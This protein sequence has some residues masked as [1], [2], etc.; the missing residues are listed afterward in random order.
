MSAYLSIVFYGTPDFAVGILDHILRQGFPVVG[1][2]TAPD[3]PAGR[4]KKL[5]PSAVK[6]YA[7]GKEIPLSQ[8]V[9]LKDPAFL[10]QLH[11][12]NPQ[13]Q[14]VVAFRMLPEEIW[15][16][17]PLG[18]FNLHASLLPQYRGAAPIQW[19]L[20]NGEKETGVTTFFIDKDIDTGK[21]ILQ[22]RVPILPE[23][24]AGSLM[25]KLMKA[26]ALLTVKT[27]ETISKEN[28]KLSGQQVLNAATLAK[29]P[30][31]TKENLFLH[32]E[33]TPEVINNRI[34]AFSPY[35]GARTH[36]QSPNGQK[37][38][39]KIFSAVPRRKNHK[40]P[41]PSFITD[42]KTFLEVTVK[43]GFVSLKEVQLKKN[44]KMDIQDFLKGFHPEGYTLLT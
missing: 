38:I 41:V 5:Q 23:D 37:M 7:L 18:T 40:Y 28:V 12:W 21:I 25:D 32:W 24:N 14:V 16:Y 10:K 44:K 26:G 36:I 1:V 22:K 29:A 34:R 11:D 2:V 17:P 42:H 6:E 33:E 27:I 39:L 13:L 35:P 3:K 43:K 15:G 19:A 9:H 8:P 4:G 30:K 20:I 31:I